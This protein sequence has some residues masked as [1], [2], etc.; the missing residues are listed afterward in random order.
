[1]SETSGTGEAGRR[2]G[3]AEGAEKREVPGAVTRA[4]EVLLSAEATF[5]NYAEIHR[6]KGTPEGDIKAAANAGREQMCR[7]AAAGLKAALAESFQRVANRADRGDALDVF[8]GFR[9]GF[10]LGE[11]AGH[12]K[13]AVGELERDWPHPMPP[14]CT[15]ED[16]LAVFRAQ[17]AGMKG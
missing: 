3:V 8:T 10:A 13:L 1:M 7:E 16:A 9:V 11:I 12:Y 2:G 17:L 15:V 5:A 6:Q 4:L 14:A